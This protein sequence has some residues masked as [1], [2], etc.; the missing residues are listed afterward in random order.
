MPKLEALCLADAFD[1]LFAYDTHLMLPTN[2]VCLRLDGL[3]RMTDQ[4]LLDY[5]YR[6]PKENVE[7]LRSLALHHMPGVR[8]IETLRLILQHLIGLEFFSFRLKHEV[9]SDWNESLDCVNDI[10]QHGAYLISP[11][12]KELVFDV[13]LSLLKPIHGRLSK[14]PLHPY[15]QVLFKSVSFCGFPKLQVYYY[16]SRSY[17]ADVLDKFI[18]PFGLT[19]RWYQ[20]RDQA[21]NLLTGEMSHTTLSQDIQP[22]QQQVHT[23]VCQPIPDIEEIVTDMKTNPSLDAGDLSRVFWPIRIR[24]Y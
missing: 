11:S 13:P 1:K 9:I 16:Q 5:I 15:L 21:G 14:Y 24:K 8:K 19:L 7:H 10:S 3:R 20:N 2:L 22:Q 6:I 23:I 18:L 12:L 4:D 17:T